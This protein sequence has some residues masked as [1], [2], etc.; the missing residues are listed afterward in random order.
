[1]CDQLNGRLKTIQKFGPPRD[2]D[3]TFHT[4]IYSSARIDVDELSKVR[5]YLEKLLGKEFV[6]R[7]ETDESAVNKV[8]SNIFD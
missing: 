3:V 5:R 6:K 8:V 4:L 7:S 1:M 2:M